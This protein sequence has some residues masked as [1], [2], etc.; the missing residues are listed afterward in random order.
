VVGQAAAVAVVV[1]GPK[2][3]AAKVVVATLAVSAFA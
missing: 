2:V 3:V 1:P